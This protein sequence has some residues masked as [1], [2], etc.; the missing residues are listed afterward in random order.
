MDPS[1]QPPVMK[2]PKTAWWNNPNP[3]SMAIRQYNRGLKVSQA[4][5]KK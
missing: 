5:N 3:L 1:K 4:E 2:K